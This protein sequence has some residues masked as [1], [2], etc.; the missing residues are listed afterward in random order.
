MGYVGGRIEQAADD[1]QEEIRRILEDRDGLGNSRF[2][3]CKYYQEAII[4]DND[5]QQNCHIWSY[6]RPFHS[7]TQGDLQTCHEGTSYT[8]AI[9][10]TYFCR[11]P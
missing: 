9:C 2:E 5:A 11:L 1:V 10:D 4:R 3:S 6:R 8:Q 7:S